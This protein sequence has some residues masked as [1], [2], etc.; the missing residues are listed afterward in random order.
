MTTNYSMV[1]DKGPTTRI[2]VMYRIIAQTID[3]FVTAREEAW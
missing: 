3:H 1:H 2:L